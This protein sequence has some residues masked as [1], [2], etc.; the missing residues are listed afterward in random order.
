MKRGASDFTARVVTFKPTGGSRLSIQ[1]LPHELN[2]FI[3]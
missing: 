2:E 1:L 3:G